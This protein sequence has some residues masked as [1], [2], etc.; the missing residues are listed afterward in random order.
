MRSSF[1]CEYENSKK[2]LLKSFPTSDIQDFF[3]VHASGTRNMGV[4]V[5]GELD[6]DSWIFL[7]ASSKIGSFKRVIPVVRFVQVH[8]Y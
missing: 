6:V 8:A 5:F 7:Q 3:S 2:P 1:V 4:F